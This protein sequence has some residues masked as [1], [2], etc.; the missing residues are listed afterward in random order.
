ML[1]TRATLVLALTLL[2]QLWLGVGAAPL[3]EAALVRAVSRDGLGGGAQVTAGPAREPGP[4]AVLSRP[5]QLPLPGID[6]E[7]RTP[8]PLRTHSG[9]TLLT[10]TATARPLAA[11]HRQDDPPAP[12]LRRALTIA[13]PG[14]APPARL[15]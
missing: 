8:R 1:P 4:I 12:A 2:T 14:R 7:R 5:D 15:A 13:V 11:T 6:G 10:A 9:A 3:N